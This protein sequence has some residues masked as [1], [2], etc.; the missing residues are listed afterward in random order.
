MRHED[1]QGNHSISRSVQLKNTFDYR[2]VI[3]EMVVR[4]NPRYVA[5][6][7]EPFYDSESPCSELAS[8]SPIY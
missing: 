2:N 6:F 3:I 1:A 7:R 5:Y 4:F 8:E